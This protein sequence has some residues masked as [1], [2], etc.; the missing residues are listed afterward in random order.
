MSNS[1]Y[2]LMIGTPAYGGMMH[3]DFVL[4]LLRYQ[5]A[6]IRF[7]LMTIGN[8]SLITRA[9]NAIISAFYEKP[10]FTHLLFIDADI[11]LPAEG[12]S[13]LLAHGKDVIGAPVALKGRTNDGRRIFNI[14]ASIGEAGA[15]LLNERIGTAVF[16][17]SR[18]AVTALVDD[19]KEDGRIYQRMSTQQGD[20]GA[21][22]HYDIFR[23]GV[24]N[25]EY[26]SEDYW[27]CA[28]LRRLGFDIH[29]DPTIVTRHHGTVS[30]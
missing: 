4:S 24:S 10:E 11:G 6:R 23:V 12:V 22:I 26:L 21:A 2:N 18:H 29:I 1:E 30:V 13:R 7:S 16:M 14:G 3:S 5:Q 17:L 9:R 8:E 27:V 19:A 20:P 25:G 15:L 28:A